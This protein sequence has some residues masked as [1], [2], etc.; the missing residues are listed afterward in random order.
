MARCQHCN[1]LTHSE[2]LDVYFEIDDYQ[3]VQELF[4]LQNWLSAWQYHSD[5]ANEIGRLK[6]GD[7]VIHFLENKK[8]E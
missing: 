8:K 7:I 2:H 4:A 6:C 3:K 1:K 5:R